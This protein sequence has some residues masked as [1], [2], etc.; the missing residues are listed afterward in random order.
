MID[1]RK[2]RI[3]SLDCIVVDG[4]PNPTIATVMCHGYGA[5]GNDLVGLSAEWIQLIGE[6]ASAFRFV[7][8]E[9]PHTLEEMGMPEGHAWW[10][11]NMARLMDLV[12]VQRFDQ[13]HGEQPPGIGEA[14]E[15]ICET[16][17]AVKKDLRGD[18]T[19]L[20]LGGFSQGAMLMLNASLR[21]DILPPN[22]LFQFSSTIVCRPQWETSLARLKDTKVFQ[23]HGTIDPLLPYASA[24]ALSEM[25]RSGGVQVEFHSFYGPHTIDREAIAITAQM[26]ASLES[27]S[28]DGGDGPILRLP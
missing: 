21:G 12:Q 13:L 5:S 10:P 17:N 27:S 8:P 11:I 1:A 26:L 14:T 19:P 23:S 28:S 22:L 4:G 15:R 25:M 18:A 2:V 7:F 6:H 20:V 24:V 16:I 9:A 3:A